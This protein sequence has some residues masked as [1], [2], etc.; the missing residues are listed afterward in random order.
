MSVNDL[1]VQ[2]VVVLPL[3]WRSWISGIS[4]KLRGTEIRDSSFW[5]LAH[6]YK[7]A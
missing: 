1:L 2:N 7:E 3:I 6:W 5:N 4:N